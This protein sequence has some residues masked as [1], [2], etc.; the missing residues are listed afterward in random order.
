LWQ[1]GI[2][3]GDTVAVIGYGFE[4]FWARLAKVKIVAEMFGWQASLLYHGTPDIKQGI[5]ETFESTGAIA[6][7]A[8]HVP[9]DA[10][11]SGW[12]QVGNSNYYIYKFISN[13]E[14]LIDGIK[15]TG[16]YHGQF[17]VH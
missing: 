16:I 12:H 15:S 1:L 17:S 9:G 5:L 14:K 10:D 4:S 7:V 8:E 13:G 6:I 11:M 2:R 3:P